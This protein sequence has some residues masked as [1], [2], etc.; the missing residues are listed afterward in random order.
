MTPQ[1]KS[2]LIKYIFR[3]FEL[4]FI[5]RPG[6]FSRHGLDRG[7][8][9]LVEIMQVRDETLVADLGCGNGI[10][11]F[12]AAKLN[13]KC[14]VHLLDDSLRAINSARE[15][16]ELNEFKNVEVYL[17]DLFSAVAD[18]SYDLI[19]SN[20]PQSLGN[21]FLEE[22]VSECF[23]HLKFQGVLMWVVKNN[24]KVPVLKMFAKFFTTGTI[25]TQNRE[26]VLIKGVKDV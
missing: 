23:L 11:G 18:R 12:V 6:V 7:S 5:T 16:V 13:Y 4:K 22:M 20:P 1:A 25:V 24:L 3:G 15:N 9:L 2:S 19:L 8:R 10:I 21:E 26:Y 17:S 14:H